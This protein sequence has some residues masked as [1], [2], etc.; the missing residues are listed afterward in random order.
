MVLHVSRPRDL[1]TNIT[2]HCLAT[3]HG[4]T[5]PATGDT[6]RGAEKHAEQTGHGTVVCM[7]GG[8]FDRGAA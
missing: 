5:C 4:D 2:W 3:G 6:Q 8:P 1:G 7:A